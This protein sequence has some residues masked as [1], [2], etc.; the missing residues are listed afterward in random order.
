[1]NSVDEDSELDKLKA[2]AAS[3]IDAVVHLDAERL[4]RE[5]RSAWK[6]DKMMYSYLPHLAGNIATRRTQVMVSGLVFFDVL[7]ACVD[8]S[9]RKAE[10]THHVG[11]FDCCVAL[12]LRSGRGGE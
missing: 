1:M 2:R 10:D 7:A 4:W 9:H 6:G 3:V 5:A 8:Q 12:A 11:K